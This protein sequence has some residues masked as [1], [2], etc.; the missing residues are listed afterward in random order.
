MSICIPLVLAAVMAGE[1]PGSA[2]AQSPPAEQE[3][4]PEVDPEGASPVR[5]IPRLEIRHGFAKLASGASVNTTTGQVDVQFFSRVLIRYELP[6]PRLTIGG[7]QIAGVGDTRVQAL[8]ALTS[9]PR[10]VSV[11]IAGLVLDTASQPPLGAG[12]SQL[13][14]GGAAALK[15]RTWWLPYLVAQEQLSFAGDAA[16]PDV[17]VLLVRLGNVLFAGQGQWFKLDL[18]TAIDFA[19]GDQRLYAT[20][21]GGRLLIGSVGLFV[22]GGSQ[23]LGPREVDYTLEVGVRY[24]FRLQKSPP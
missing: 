19:D 1:A 22:R 10:Q 3:P 16:R 9:G 24:L 2:A 6:L 14:F 5:L 23:L 11:L 21:E 15:P 4:T 12:K 18:D 8:T 20:L 17:N 13:F 7:T